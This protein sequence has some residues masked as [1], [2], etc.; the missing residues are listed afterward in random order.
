MNYQTRLG[1]L[2]RTAVVR[3]FRHDRGPNGEPSRDDFMATE[4]PRIEKYFAEHWDDMPDWQ[5]NPRY[6]QRT[7]RGSLAYMYH[8]IGQLDPDRTITLAELH[9]DLEWPDHPDH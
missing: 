7:F 6:K 2:F 9:I 8:V 4:L 1:P 5:G 3:A